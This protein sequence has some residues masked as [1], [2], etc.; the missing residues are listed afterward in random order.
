MAICLEYQQVYVE[1]ARAR[2]SWR[3]HCVGAGCLLVALCAKVWVK[4]ESTQLGYTLA[5]EQ[6]RTVELDMQRRELA[7]QYSVMSRPD[8]LAREAHARLGLRAFDPGQ[9]RKIEHGEKGAL[10]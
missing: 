4:L 8:R 2:H 5:Q 3:W 1:R 9:V 10:Q 7:L 6:A